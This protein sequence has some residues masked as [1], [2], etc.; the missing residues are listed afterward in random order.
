M[1]VHCTGALRVSCSLILVALGCG[2]TSPSDGTTNSDGFSGPPVVHGVDGVR[3]TTLAGSST[4][5]SQ[6][7]VGA[8]ALFDNPV[9]VALDGSGALYVTEYDGARVRKVTS[10]GVT[11]LVTSQKEFVGPFA[12]VVAAPDH[13]LVQTDFDTS[14]IKTADTSGTLWNIP[15]ATGVARPFVPGLGRPRGLVPGSGTDVFVVDARRH[16][17]SRLGA[18]GQLTLIAGATDIPGYV[19]GAGASARFNTPLGVARTANGDLLIADSENHCLRR[20]GAD[21][22]VTTF[23]GDGTRGMIDGPAAQARF[24]RPIALAIDAGGNVYVSDQGINHRI[25]RVSAAGEVATFAGNGTAGFAD[26]DGA[27][28]AFY[29]QE[30]MTIDLTQTGVVLYLADGNAGDGSAHHRLRKLVGP[31]P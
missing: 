30:G 20:V 14:G 31:T 12:I 27:D 8:G 28:A 18:Q 5:G 21:G 11:S 15:F 7:G 9:G 17:V 13:L 23:A 16:T 3:V 24:D 19:D 2:G 4:S 10:A 22:T 25:R 1:R 26:G 29:G 6:D